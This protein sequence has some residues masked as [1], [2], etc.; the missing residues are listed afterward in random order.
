M[1]PVHFIFAV[2]NHQPVGNFE[3]VLG[4]CFKDFYL[5]VLDFVLEYSSVRL[6]LDYSGP[7][8]QFIE[9]RHPYYIERLRSLAARNQ[10]ELMGGGFY[11]PIPTAIPPRDAL[12]QIRKM[13]DWLES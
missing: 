12:G 3:A 9:K 1:N 11:E 7:L 8:L 6:A 5:T 10:I 4:G 2:H 13:A